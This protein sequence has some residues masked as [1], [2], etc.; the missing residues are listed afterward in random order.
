MKKK[1]SISQSDLETFQQ[2]MKEVKPVHKDKVPLSPPPKKIRKTRKT[3]L[4]DESVGLS[5]T[6][7]LPMLGAEGYIVYKQH[8]ISNK[9]LRKLRKGQYNVEATLDLHGMTINAAKIAVDHFLQQCL[10]DGIRIALI[11]HGKGRGNQ[12]PVLKNKLNQWLRGVNS[13]LAFCSAATVHGSRGAMYIM[14]KKE[15]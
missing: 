13:I 5:E 8:G 4:D 6:D 7:D 10:R 3:E 9:M 2:A 14:L 15:S 1:S 11:I 12:Q